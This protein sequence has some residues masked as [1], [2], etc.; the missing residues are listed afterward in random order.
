[1]YPL[2]Y[3]DDNEEVAAVKR[4]IAVSWPEDIL[5]DLSLFIVLFEMGAE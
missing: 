2:S 5:D 4:E 1:M 3:L